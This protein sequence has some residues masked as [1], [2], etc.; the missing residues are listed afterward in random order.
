MSKNIYSREY[1]V[2]T[3]FLCQKCLRCDNLLSFKQCQCDLSKKVIIREMRKSYSRVYD[4]ITK[5]NI[6]NDLQLS[7]LDKANK[8]YS[9]GID[10][11]QKFKYCLCSKCHSLMAR[12][13]K[14]KKS[15]STNMSEIS[16][17]GSANSSSSKSQNTSDSGDDKV[18]FDENFEKMIDVEQVKNLDIETKQVVDN[19]E[20]EKSENDILKITFKLVIMRDGKNSPAKWETIHRTD[21]NNFIKDLHIIIQD[22]VNEFM[23]RND[24]I[25]SYRHAKGSGIG[26]YLLNETDWIMF[27]KEYQDLS[28]QEEIMM[29]IASLNFKSNRIIKRFYYR[30]ELQES[31]EKKENLYTNIVPEKSNLIEDKIKVAT[32]NVTLISQN[33]YCDEHKRPCYIKDLNHLHLTPQHLSI[34]AASIEYGL[35]TINEPPF[36]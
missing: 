1:Q 25:I 18:E 12:L 27:L 19:L 29:I 23:L 20:I 21:Y 4:P 32:T 8:L 22:Q 2:G 7:E 14:S 35:A 6:Y 24:F 3:C 28:S 34:W 9:Y 16:N 13:R 11:S 10:F 5:H 17:E 30:N 33:H 26:N 31:K 36:T 15:L